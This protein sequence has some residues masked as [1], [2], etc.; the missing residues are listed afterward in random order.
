M[1]AY[2]ELYHKYDLILKMD[3]NSATP[4]VIVEEFAQFLPFRIKW[5]RANIVSVDEL[6]T[7]L[8]QCLQEFLENRVVPPTRS[9]I[10][11]I[12]SHLDVASYNVEQILRKN[13][14]ID[15][16]DYFWIRLDPKQTIHYDD[17]RVRD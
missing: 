7:L 4:V 14:G 5:L 2:M 6:E 3:L 15:T 11:D 17:I 12:L 1:I 9:N 16:D 13:Y 8:L 10:G